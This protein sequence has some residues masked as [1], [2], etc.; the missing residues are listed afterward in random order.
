MIVNSRHVCD[1]PCSDHWIYGDIRGDQQKPGRSANKMPWRVLSASKHP[2]TSFYGS[3]ENPV[4]EAFSF[5][6]TGT[7]AE[8]GRICPVGYVTP[9]VRLPKSGYFARF[10]PKNL[11][12]VRQMRF[13]T[14]TVG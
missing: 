9:A 5:S 8:T 14:G 2:P 1:I 6:P 4:F 12:A 3:C 11:V 13:P 10:L 7:G